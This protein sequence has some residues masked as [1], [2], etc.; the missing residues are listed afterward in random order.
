LVDKSAQKIWISYANSP[1]Q[2]L[3]GLHARHFRF[4]KFP[5]AILDVTVSP[6]VW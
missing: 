6:L 4:F 3:F 5:V 1:Y 2:T